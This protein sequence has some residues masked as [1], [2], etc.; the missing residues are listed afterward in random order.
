MNS[1][2]LAAAHAHLELPWGLIGVFATGRAQ[3][4]SSSGGQQQLLIVKLARRAS[5]E[6]WTACSASG[7]RATGGAHV[8]RGC[9]PASGGRLARAHVARTRESTQSGCLA[10]STWLACSLCWPDGDRMLEKMP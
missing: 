7:A 6:A 4:A 10:A 8:P 3:G 5:R 1:V 9:V 2:E